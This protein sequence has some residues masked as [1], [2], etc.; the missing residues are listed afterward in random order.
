MALFPRLV[1]LHVGSILA[2]S[3]CRAYRRVYVHAFEIKFGRGPRQTQ[4]LEAE[5]KDQEAI[6]ANYSKPLAIVMIF[7]RLKACQHRGVSRR[8]ILEDLS[9]SERTLRNYL[10]FVRDMI[11]PYILRGRAELVCMRNGHDA[12]YR[13]VVQR[14]A[15]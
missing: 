6:V 1:A 3:T 15:S 4:L 13:L 14:D 10:A 5:D 11:I 2:R 7:E 12:Y 8:E 9:I